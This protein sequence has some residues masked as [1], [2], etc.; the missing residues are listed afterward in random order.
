M[1]FRLTCEQE[2]TLLPASRREEGRGAEPCSNAEA[3]RGTKPSAALWQ[4]G[5]VEGL[6]FGAADFFFAL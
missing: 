3:G 1:P 4:G 2:K 6:D 5:A